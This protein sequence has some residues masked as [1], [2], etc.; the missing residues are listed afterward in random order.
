MLQTHSDCYS[1]PG[2][3]GQ[4]N[5]KQQQQRHLYQKGN[6]FFKKNLFLL[7]HH[8]SCCVCAPFLGR[9]GTE[10]SGLAIEY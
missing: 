1:K 8:V 9:G 5:G 3:T 7:Q 2:L 10:R 4:V 6:C